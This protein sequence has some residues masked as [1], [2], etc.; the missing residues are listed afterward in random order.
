[1]VPSKEPWYFAIYSVHKNASL[2]LLYALIQRFSLL[3]FKCMVFF[4]ILTH[5]SLRKD[6][7]KSVFESSGDTDSDFKQF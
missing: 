4:L 3:T 6:E 1:M 7:E 2:K 5:T